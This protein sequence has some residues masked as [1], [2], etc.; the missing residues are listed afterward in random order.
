MNP[1]TIMESILMAPYCISGQFTF[2]KILIHPFS[3]SRSLNP[4]IQVISKTLTPFTFNVRL[5]LLS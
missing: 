1:Y 5:K 2:I 3:L 4:E